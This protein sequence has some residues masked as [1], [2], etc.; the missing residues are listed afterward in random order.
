MS[1]QPHTL[2]AICTGLLTRPQATWRA[3]HAQP[4]RRV[5]WPALALAALTVLLVFASAHADAHYR[6]GLALDWFA[7]QAMGNPPEL[8]FAPF[9][10]TA[11]QAARELGAL[12]LR[13][14]AWTGALFVAGRAFG[15]RPLAWR[16][17][18]AL[19][20]WGWLPLILRGLLQLAF[21]ARARAPIYNPGLSGLAF[22]ATPPPLTAFRYVTPTASQWL[23]AS[24]LRGVDLFTVWHGL[25][26]GWGLAAFAQMSPRQ[27]LALTALLWTAALLLPLATGV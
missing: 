2:P 7:Q 25:L 21:V 23:A 12:A 8:R 11:L 16:D 14:A 17:A 27:A 1:A 4:R 26:T 20:L 24:L 5:G 6:H 19:A 22:D 13:G 9:E 18:L 10:A 3:L 15:K